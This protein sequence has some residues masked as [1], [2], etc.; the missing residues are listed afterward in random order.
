MKEFNSTEITLAQNSVF[1]ARTKKIFQKVMEY[2]GLQG[3]ILLATADGQ[4]VVSTS[5]DNE[6]ASRYS[7]LS[8]ALLALSE[9]FSTELLNISNNEISVSSEGGHAALIRLQLRNQ[10]FLLCLSST[11][12]TVNLAT[13][14]RLA[15]DVSKKLQTTV[16]Y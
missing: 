16:N 5:T 4:T 11:A 7:A 13:V 1:I 8:C 9:S 12:N 14:I 2:M 3:H 15:R 6:K 10:S